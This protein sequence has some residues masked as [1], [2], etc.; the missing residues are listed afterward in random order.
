MLSIGEL[1]EKLIIENIKIFNIRDK[2]HKKGIDNK[3]YAD[4]YSKMMSLNDNKSVLSKLLDEKVE[5]VL[6]KKEK[7]RILNTIKTY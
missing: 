5:R 4:L 7:N 3:E 6:L 1:S 2:L